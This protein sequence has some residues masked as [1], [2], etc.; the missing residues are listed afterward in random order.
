MYN[1]CNEVICIWSTSPLSWESVQPKWTV[2]KEVKVEAVIIKFLQL[3]QN[4]HQLPKKSIYLA[5]LKIDRERTFQSFDDILTQLNFLWVFTRFYVILLWGKKIHT[6]SSY[7]PWAQCMSPMIGEKS[8]SGACAYAQEWRD[9]DIWW[10][11]EAR[12]VRW[13]SQCLSL[14][15]SVLRPSWQQTGER[16]NR[17]L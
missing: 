9:V 10:N 12:R 7:G 8:L 14:S 1:I 4:K 16:E 17:I 6:H 11:F 2:I 5:V 15:S 3:L 13:S